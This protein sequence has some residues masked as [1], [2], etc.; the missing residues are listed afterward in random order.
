VDKGCD[1]MKP[2]VKW[3]TISGRDYQ[4]CSECEHTLGFCKCEITGVGLCGEEG[5]C[6]CD[7]EL[8]DFHPSLGR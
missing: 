3:I 1:E 2:E 6:D 8:E 7:S 4:V 5:C